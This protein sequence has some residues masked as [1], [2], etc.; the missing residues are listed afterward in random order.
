MGLG[1][2]LRLLHRPRYERRRDWWQIL[3]DLINILG[4]YGRPWDAAITVLLPN[5]FPRGPR[6]GRCYP[7]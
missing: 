3:K 4:R 7:A 6:A 2:D 5:S 1:Q